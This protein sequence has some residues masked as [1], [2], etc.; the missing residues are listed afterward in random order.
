MTGYV[1]A[2]VFPSPPPS[3]HVKPGKKSWVPLIN[4]RRRSCGHVIYENKNS[5][6]FKIYKFITCLT[7]KNKPDMSNVQM[8]LT[9]KVLKCKQQLQDNSAVVELQWGPMKNVYLSHF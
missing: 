7:E 5:E 4:S 1:K 2:A 9:C 8:T 6:Q 3:P